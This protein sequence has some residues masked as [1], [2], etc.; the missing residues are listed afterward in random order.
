[1]NH[2]QSG[3]VTHLLS[4]GQGSSRRHALNLLTES[5]FFAHLDLPED[6]QT[7]LEAFVATHGP[8]GN[9]DFCDDGIGRLYAAINLPVPGKAPATPE[10]Q[11]D[12]VYLT[13]RVNVHRD[14]GLPPFDED[15]DPVQSEHDAVGAIIDKAMTA[16]GLVQG[17]GWSL[18]NVRLSEWDL[19]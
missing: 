9:G 7:K 14:L 1:M 15:G 13:V 19:D 16:L 18:T 10:P 5:G 17:E 8:T 4:S 6:S 3:V 2:I 12:E 11:D